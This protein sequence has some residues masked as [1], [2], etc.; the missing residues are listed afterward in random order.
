MKCKW[1][2]GF[3]NTSG[4]KIKVQIMVKDTAI[5]SICSIPILYEY[6]ARQMDEGA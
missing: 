6:L 4:I 5:L 1:A 2:R 3:S